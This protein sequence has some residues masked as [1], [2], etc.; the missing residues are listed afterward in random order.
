VTLVTLEYGVLRAIARGAKRSSRRFGGALELFARLSVR[1]VVKEGLC[2]LEEADVV[3]I[4]PAI[5]Q[6]LG[7]IGFAS[8][9]CEVIGVLLPE[10]MANGRVFRLLDAYLHQLHD[11]SATVS[12][13]RFFEVNLLNIL[14][15]RPPLDDCAKCGADLSTQGGRWRQGGSGGIYCGRCWQDGERIGAGALNCLRRALQTAFLHCR[16]GGVALFVPDYVREIFHPSTEHGGRDDECRGLRY[17][18]WAYDPDETDDTYVTEMVYLLRE[19]DRP[20][21]VEYERHLCGLFAREEWL[22]LLVEAGFRPEVVP[23]GYGREL[24]VARRSVLPSG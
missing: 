17:L 16:P 2:A 21:R 20:L 22:R 10:G 6:D 12:D 3:T 24:F 7:K 15:Y 14:G 19:G 23:D 5:R 4:F 13:R 1:L 11:A 8:Y 9:A 18:E